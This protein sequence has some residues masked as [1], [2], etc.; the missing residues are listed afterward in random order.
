MPADPKIEIAPTD[1]VRCDRCGAQW[2]AAEVA[3]RLDC[4]ATTSRGRCP[5]GDFDGVDVVDLSHH[6]D[7]KHPGWRNR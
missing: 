2:E 4:Q 6:F 5:S 7:E 3:D 1:L